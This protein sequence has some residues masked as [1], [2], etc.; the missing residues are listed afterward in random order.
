MAISI[1]YNPQPL[2]L[3]EADGD[4]AAGA[5]AYF[6]L[7]LTTTPMTVYTDA[8]VATPHT[9]PVVADAY[10]LLPPIY[11]PK[12]VDY[13]IRIHDAAGVILY[14][15]DNIDNP[16]E[17]TGSGGSEDPLVITASMVAKTG[18]FD[19][20][21][22]NDD[23][24]GWVRCN[25]G[26]ISSLAGTGT[27][28]KNDDCQALFAFFWNKFSD[29][30]CPVTPGPR[31]PNPAA[32]W[33]VNKAIATLDMRGRGAV[34]LDKMGPVIPA[35]SRIQAVTTANTTSANPILYVASHAG[36]CAGM[37]V[38][39][40]NVPAGT[41]VTAL[42]NIGG[43][44]V[45]CSANA[46][47]TGTSVPVRFSMFADAQVPGSPGGES[48]HVQSVPEMALHVHGSMGMTTTIT[49]TLST[50]MSTTPVISAW[51]ADAG[52]LRSTSTVTDP[53]HFH[54]V[55]TDA[56]TSNQLVGRENAPHA[57]AEFD[58]LT[59]PSKDSTSVNAIAAAKLTG[60][61]VGTTTG[62]WTYPTLGAG[63]T[64]Y[65]QYTT[66]PGTLTVTPSG[67]TANTGGSQPMNIQTPAVLGTWYAKL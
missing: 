52:D 34:G 14:A 4:F 33:G 58:L 9:W 2:R 59:G 60:I 37:F 35:A 5:L 32:D 64:T 7:A 23:R 21:P 49:G 40:G 12:G 66:T 6:Y 67:N 39:G 8:A 13:K 16:G 1:L 45:T 30:M 57:N 29:A 31:G 38:T 3:F 41:K 63:F 43:L 50:T 26:T 17:A 27:E 18:D 51:F 19:W 28:Y 22:V 61:T 24:P 11:I 44:N 15:A 36:I 48:T 20:Q 42:G 46:P 54:N 56:D 53:T 25:G 65:P 10:G 55:T 62:Y 47:A